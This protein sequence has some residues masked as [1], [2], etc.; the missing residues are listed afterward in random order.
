VDA[1]GTSVTPVAKLLPL[2]EDCV[3]T[4][5]VVPKTQLAG[6]VATKAT[7]ELPAP[8]TAVNVAPVLYTAIFVELAKVEEFPTKTYDEAPEKLVG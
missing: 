4:D 2:S 7:L 1:S 8:S 6:V 5:L 3:V